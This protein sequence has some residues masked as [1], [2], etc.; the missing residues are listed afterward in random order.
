MGSVTTT[1]SSTPL[2]RSALDV[3]TVGMQ[4]TDAYGRP[5]LHARLGAARRRLADPDLAVL[6]VGE[7]KQGK[8]SLINSILKVPVCPVDDD[9]S[10]AVPT[11]V[12]HGPEP[13]AVAIIEGS[14]GASDGADAVPI[15]EPVDPTELVQWVSEAGNPGNYKGLRSAEVRIPSRL[16]EQ[17]LA[18]VDTP[19]VGGL[20]SVHGV[21]TMGALP[22]AEAVLFV[23][24]ASQEL[25]AAEL[26]FLVHAHDVCANVICV[27]TKIDLH[28]AWRGILERNERHLG[29][30]GLDLRFLAVSSLLRQEAIRHDDVDLNEESGYPELLRFLTRDV[31]AAAGEVTVSSARRDVIRVVDQLSIQ[32]EAERVALEDPERAEELVAELERAQARAADLRSRSAK[33]Q[34]TLGDGV[35]DITADVDH[36]LRER[37]RTILADIEAHLDENDPAEIWAEF[38]PWIRQRVTADM[39]ANY[40]LLAARAEQV[41]ASIADH[42][43]LEESVARFELTIATPQELIDQ[44]NDPRGLDREDE[45]GRAAGALTAVRGSYG[46]MLMFSMLTNLVGLAVFAPMTLAIGAGMGRKALREDNKRRLAMRRQ[47]A[48]TAARRFVDDTVFVVGKDS[49]DTVR[50]I[51]RELRDQ[52]TEHAQELQRSTNDALAAAKQAVGVDHAERGRRLRNVTAELQRIEGLRRQADA[53]RAELAPVGAA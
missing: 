28:P 41:A 29:R 52:F 49:R 33:W 4:A 53:L 37:A 23:T 2:V 3:V 24:D 40:Q 31:L 26:D 20:D 25:S 38:E 47:Q 50:K 15:E 14:A 42:F 18:L 7:F 11:V 32:F 16:L 8:S 39:V 5:D 22:M 19:G 44:L 21:V 30:A 13:T 46:G 9:V 36:D 1:K 10:T 45:P 35:Q 48:K 12:R 51:H 6:V 34:Q 43:A 17:G 27:L